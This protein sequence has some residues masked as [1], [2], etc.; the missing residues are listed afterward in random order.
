MIN[1]YKQMEMFCFEFSKNE[2]KEN[3]K[4]CLCGENFDL[5]NHQIVCFS[6]VYCLV[7]IVLLKP[8]AQIG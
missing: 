1:P 6:C 4:K 2:K 8:V 7:S 5:D 3:N